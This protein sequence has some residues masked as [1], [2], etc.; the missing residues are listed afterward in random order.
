MVETLYFNYNTI[1]D[2]LILPDDGWQFQE[3]PEPVLES[4]DSERQS[5]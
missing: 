3:F 4:V 5:C 2:E 1:P